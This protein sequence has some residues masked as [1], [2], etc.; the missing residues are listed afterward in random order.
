MIIK[1]I[2]QFKPRK[3]YVIYGVFMNHILTY[4]QMKKIMT[5]KEIQILIEKEKIVEF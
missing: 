2:K 3:K 4:K 5:E 1:D